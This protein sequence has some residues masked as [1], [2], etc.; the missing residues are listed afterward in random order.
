MLRRPIANSLIALLCR[1]LLAPLATAWQSASLLACCRRNGKH[2]CMSRVSA[3]SASMAMWMI[4]CLDLLLE[5]PNL[6]LKLLH[7]FFERLDT[8]VGVGVFVTTLLVGH[9]FSLHSASY[10]APLENSM[11]GLVLSDSLRVY[12]KSR[13]QPAA[14]RSFS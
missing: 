14:G 7:L 2:Q 6:L 13:K 4:V 8:L 12:A 1:A 10:F 3:A 11:T 5:I 9:K